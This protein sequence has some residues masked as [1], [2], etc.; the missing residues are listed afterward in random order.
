MIVVVRWRRYQ[1][2]TSVD[3]IEM[4]RRDSDKPA[5]G[6]IPPP[7]LFARVADEKDSILT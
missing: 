2:G 5:L 6:L 1:V 7:P 4:R 3:G